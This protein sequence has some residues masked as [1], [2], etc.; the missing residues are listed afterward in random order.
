LLAGGTFL[1]A[2]VDQGFIQHQVLI[3]NDMNLSRESVA[4]AVSAIGLVGI[5]C[6]ILAGNILDGTSNKGL[7]LLYGTLTLSALAA[8][9]LV[10]PIVLMAFVVLRAAGHAAVLVDTTVMTKHV[11]GL[12]NFGTMVGIFTAIT[13]V[14][15]AAGPW[16]MGRLYD[17]NGNYH[18]AF[19]LFAAMPLA[20]AVMT[21]MLKPTFWHALRANAKPVPHAETKV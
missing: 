6:R 3:L 13:S 1:T 12:K 21:W 5:V 14:G 15:F 2:I 4:L 19:I 18:V 11:F 9:Y 10:S 8:F 20:A 16:I 7:S 17:L